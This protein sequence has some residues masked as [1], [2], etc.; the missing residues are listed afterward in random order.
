ME[1]IKKIYVAGDSLIS[2]LG[3]TTA[4]NREALKAGLTGIK[5]VHDPALYSEGFPAARIDRV[6]WKE[7]VKKARLENYAPLEQLFI[8]CIGQVSRLTGINLRDPEVGLILAS[9]KGNID[10]IRQ[11]SAYLWKMGQ[12]IA[13]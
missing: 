6:R 3:F 4:E 11:P 2:S 9:T 8:L 7:E 1:E 10:Q 13:E 5:E 12:R